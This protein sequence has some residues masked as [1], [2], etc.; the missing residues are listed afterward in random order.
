MVVHR[1]KMKYK[2][3][4]WIEKLKPTLEFPPEEGT[5]GMHISDIERKF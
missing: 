5:L 4:R 3:Q 1:Q 2:I